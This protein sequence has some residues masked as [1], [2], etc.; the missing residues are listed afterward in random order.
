MYFRCAAML[1]AAS[2]ASSAQAQTPSAE[3]STRVFS[4]RQALAQ[5]EVAAPARAE[6]EA[7]LRAAQA[8]R[9]PAPEHSTASPS[10][11]R[12][13]ARSSRARRCSARPSQP[14]PNCSAS[15]TLGR[16]R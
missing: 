9:A 10:V 2:C 4:L 5:A 11:H 13:Q 7:G 16:Y 6:A 8:S 14:M 1:A 12:S 15:P 3:R